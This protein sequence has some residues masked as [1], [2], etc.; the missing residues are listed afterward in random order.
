MSVRKRKWRNSDGSQGE[1]WVVN[2]TDAGRKRRLKS[3]D[4]KREAESF[5]AAVGV[6]VRGG[7][8]VPDSQ[9]ITVAE[10]GRLWITSCEAADLER[11]T[12]DAYRQRV[13]LHII[14]LIGAVKLS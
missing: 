13:T 11:S 7:I 5:E 10:A 6:D 8:H 1:A 9:S 2:Y 12:L 14:P 3:F 4:R